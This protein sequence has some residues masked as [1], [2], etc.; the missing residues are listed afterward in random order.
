ME[1]RGTI[2]LV[3][4]PSSGKST[5]FNRLTDSRKE[6]TG[7][8]F[9]ITRDRNYGT[10]HW[11]DKEFTLID[12]GGVTGEN[13]PFQKEVQAQ[14]ELAIQEADVIFFVVDGRLGITNADSLVAKKL[15]PYKN[16]VFL[17][18]NKID[19]QTLVGGSYDF[20]SLGYSRLFPI[21]AEHGLGIGDLLDEAIK[22]LPVKQTNPYEGALTFALLRTPECRKILLS[23]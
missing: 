1:T 11:L 4:S 9:G 8:E 22:L 13:I 7:K 18:V 10:G 19:D 14:V 15:F 2:A 20:L 6:I 16:K 21:S 3:G 5:L 23:Q 12:T 17:V